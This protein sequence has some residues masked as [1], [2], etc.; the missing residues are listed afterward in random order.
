MLKPDWPDLSLGTVYRNLSL[1]KEEGLAISVGVVKGQERFDGNVTP[2]CHLFCP[3]GA[4]IDIDGIELDTELDTRA[5]LLSGCEIASH[6]IVFHGLC[7]ECKN[8]KEL[9]GG[10]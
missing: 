3:C 4:V 9:T 1:F 10:N 2:H 7:P 6:E 8:K 5:S